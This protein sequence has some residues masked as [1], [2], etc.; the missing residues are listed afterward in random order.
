MENATFTAPLH[1]YICIDCLDGIHAFHFIN[2]TISNS[3]ENK[4]FPI[5]RYFGRINLPLVEFVGIHSMQLIDLM[6][7]SYE[8]SG[9]IRTIVIA[10][11]DFSNL[12]GNFLSL[13]H[14][15][16]ER[17]IFEYVPENL[18]MDILFGSSKEWLLSEVRLS[19]RHNQMRTIAA[20][21][22]T[23]LKYLDSLDLSDC[24]ID[25]ILSGAFDSIAHVLERVYLDRN[26]LLTFPIDVFNDFI[27]KTCTKT[28]FAIYIRLNPLRA[29]C[30]MA[31][32]QSVIEFNQRLWKMPYELEIYMPKNFLTNRQYCSNLQSIKR[33]QM[34]CKSEDIDWHPKFSLKFDFNR[35]QIMISAPAARRY[36]LLTHNFIDDDF[37]SNWFQTYYK[38]SLKA[39]LRKAMKCVILS[40]AKE[41][42]PLSNFGSLTDR[43][44]IF[45]VNYVTTG[46]KVFWPFHC[47]THPQFISG[48][49]LVFFIDLK[50]YFVGLVVGAVA[51]FA[52]GCGLG[53]GFMIW[54]IGREEMVE[55]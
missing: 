21:N 25:N 50:M 54:K 8:W 1:R 27:M 10:D 53:I 40:H 32:F 3:T 13:L 9:M 49:Q 6:L 22:F 36:R 19:S 33:S 37:H 34:C 46:S 51:M 42:I 2:C 17:L 4:N 7:D 45:C 26:N 18:N 47:V 43:F 14:L 29:D 11:T 16:L 52:I 30:E 48:A 5:P 23:G 12:S 20:S 28:R 15:T 41:T 55:R 31:E 38:C 44:R 24:K 39:F 35:D